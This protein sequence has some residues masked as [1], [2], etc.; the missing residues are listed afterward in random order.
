MKKPHGGI[1]FVSF[2]LTVLY[3]AL[4]DRPEYL[5]PKDDTRQNIIFGIFLL[6][7]IYVTLLLIYTYFKRNRF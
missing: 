7:G 2:L 4:D 1:L 5:R 6:G 3:F